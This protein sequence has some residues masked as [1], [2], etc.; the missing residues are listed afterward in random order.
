MGQGAGGTRRYAQSRAIQGPA[1]LV[2]R[3]SVADIRRLLWQ[4]VFAVQ[5]TVDRVLAWSHWRRQHQDR[6]RFGTAHAVV[7]CSPI[8]NCSTKIYTIFDW[9]FF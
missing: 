9:S 7:P 6:R 2:I 1:R 5:Q 8:Y 3:L 4:V